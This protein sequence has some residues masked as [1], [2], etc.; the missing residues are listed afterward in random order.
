MPIIVTTKMMRN[1]TIL[2]PRV[3]YRRPP[4]EIKKWEKVRSDWL[5]TLRPDSLFHRLFDHIPDVYFFAKNRQGH[6]MFASR[7]LQRRYS[8][9]DES[10]ILGMTDFDLNPGSM[11]QSYVDDD[12]QLLQGITDSLERIELWWDNQGIPDWF[13]VIKLPVYDRQGQVQGVIGLLRRPDEAE[14]KLPVYQTV[15]RAVEIIRRDFGKSLMIEQ[16]AQ[17]CGQSVRQ[18][19]RHF[20]AAFGITPQEFLIKTRVLAAARVL[21]STLLSVSEI[22]KQCGFTDQSAFTLHFRKRTGQTPTEYRRR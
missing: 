14:R 20:Q 10:E 8:M 18:L 17:S 7:E 4:Q 5:A 12:E 16:I 19:Q 1:A 9:Q 22:A 13:L 6:L 11:A 2:K 3:L 15:A 21:E